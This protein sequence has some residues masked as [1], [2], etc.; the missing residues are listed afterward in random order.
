M[1]EF[2]NLF[3]KEVLLPKG[4][5]AYR[6]VD[7]PN[8]AAK[9]VN[10]KYP[11]DKYD[12]T[13]IYDK[14]TDFSEAKDE[15]LRIAQQKFG[16]KEGVD[17]PFANGDEREQALFKGKFIVRAKSSKRPGVVNGSCEQITEPEI[18]PG[19]KGRI[20]VSPMTYKSGKT[21]GVTFILRNVQV[22]TNEEFEPLSAGQTAAQVFGGGDVSDTAKI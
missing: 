15:C 19:M 7:S 18:T 20:H 1:P 13:L 8:T 21:K 5:I 3:G 11:S 9:N 12:I 16:T 10:N 22:F 6:D 17:L 14:S 2:D 4:V